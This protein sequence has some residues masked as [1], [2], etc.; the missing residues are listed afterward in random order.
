[1]KTTLGYVFTS[2][3]LP[4]PA[5]DK[6]WKISQKCIYRRRIDRIGFDLSE[7]AATLLFL[8]EI[9]LS[10]RRIQYTRW[11]KQTASYSLDLRVVNFRKKRTD[12]FSKFFHN[13][14]IKLH[15]IFWGL[16]ALHPDFF[17]LFTKKAVHGKTLF[18]C[19]R[20]QSF[21]C[22]CSGERNYAQRSLVLLK[23][24]SRT[25][26]RIKSAPMSPISSYAV[27]CS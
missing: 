12:I 1:M 15:L 24:S 25:L 13:A 21:N 27:V 22:S 2:S 7:R 23:N 10:I 6:W 26:P 11:P 14:Q 5:S 20:R 19:I 8:F 3:K 17:D 16:L 9:I 18:R 4:I